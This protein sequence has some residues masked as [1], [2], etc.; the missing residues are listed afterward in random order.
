MIRVWGRKTSSNVQALM[1]CIGELGLQ[2]E[3][4]DI[5]HK[6]G[7]N[8]T[9][10]FLAMNPNGTVPVIRD[11]E[12][13]ALWETGAILR[14]LAGKYGAETFWPKDAERRAH[15]DKWT[16]WAKIGVA[17]NFTAPVFWM[18]VRTAAKDQDHQA[19][20]KSLQN[21]NKKL[22]IAE[23]QIARYGY[24]AG[25][26]FTLADIQFGHSLYRYFNIAIDRPP[27]PAIEQYYEKLKQ[28]PA[29]AEH[30][31]VSYEE[32]RVV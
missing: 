7:G 16:E 3:R 2:Y 23:A 30:V 11:G 10:E 20:T 24:L 21:L 25:S 9:P 1:W 17:M 18:V 22:A 12:G 15:I 13:E 32:L 5:G 27:Y 6:Y 26:E 31:M 4:T 14:Y 28:R 29:F 8:D 19:L